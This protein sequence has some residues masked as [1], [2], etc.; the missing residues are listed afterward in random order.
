MGGAPVD[1]ADERRGRG[2]KISPDQAR[3]LCGMTVRRSAHDCGAGTAAAFSAS[4][5]I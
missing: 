4:L 5:R 1:A 2:G 3:T